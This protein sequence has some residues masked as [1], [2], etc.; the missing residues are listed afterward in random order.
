[1][2][3]EI[4]TLSRQGGRPYNED[5]FGQW[6]NERFVAC[7][8]ADGA[9]GHGGGDVAAATARASVLGGFS[10]APALEAESIRKLVE[11]ANVDVVARQAEGG[12]LAAMRS[13]VVFA[14]IDLDDH[15]LTWAH[16]G[17]SRAYLFR[18][19]AI[20][21]RTTDH[22]LVQQMVASGMIDEEGARLHPQRNMLLS[23]LGSV[24]E[25]PEISVSDRMKVEAGDVLLLCSDGVWEPLGDECLLDTLHAS[26]NPTDW[27]EQLDKQIKAR[28]KPGHDNYTAVTLWMTPDG[29]DEDTQL[30]P[31]NL[32]AA[33]SSG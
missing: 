8:V 32:A 25:P 16:S 1:V 4:I 14:V 9:G 33:G 5:V 2:Q 22:S 20:V 3:I 24:D 12:K 31:G 13:T 15:V 28:A 27:T 10:A 23:A 17:D 26:R 21:A 29:D 11:Q 18:G 19:G 30:M 6:H 7:L